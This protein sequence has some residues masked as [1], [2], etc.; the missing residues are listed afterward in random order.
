MP[1]LTAADLT[2]MR[3]LLAEEDRDGHYLDPTLAQQFLPQ[4]LAEVEALQAEVE[5]ARLA[6]LR[7]AATLVDRHLAEL[8]RSGNP[9][10]GC[11]H[12]NDSEAR[13][14]GAALLMQADLDGD[15]RLKG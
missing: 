8:A 6:A 15:R 7:E 10:R 9:G 2:E 5:G 14:L 1:R 13:R 12:C 4:L 11:A 3:R